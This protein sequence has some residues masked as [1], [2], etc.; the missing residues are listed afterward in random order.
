MRNV[1]IITLISVISI[2]CVFSAVPVMLEL[3]NHD[4]AAMTV[5]VHMAN[6]AGCALTGEAYN[7]GITDSTLCVDNGNGGN[8]WFSGAVGGFQFTISGV[9]G[10]NVVDDATSLIGANGFEASVNATTGMVL[11]FSLSGT[12]IPVD[13][14]GML[15]KLGYTALTTTS[16]CFTQT[17]GCS[18]PS[19]TANIISD[20]S[21]SCIDSQWDDDCTL[22]ISGFSANLV[23]DFSITQ[24]YPNPFN[25]VTGITF[26]VAEVDEISLK[27]YD[28]AGKEVKT[29]ASGLY[30]PGSYNVKWNALNNE[31]HAISSGMYIYRFVSSNKTITRKMLYLK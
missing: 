22:D 23:D 12:T 28:L 8:N 11:G 30:T 9:E 6:S 14:D 27:V 31:G 1:K 29:L 18:V 7:T 24:N 21:S 5:E 13:Q 19:S 10:L 4:S 16:V 26:D 20:S 15:V 3:K 25:P 17:T 2:S